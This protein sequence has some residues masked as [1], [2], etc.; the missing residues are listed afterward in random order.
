[1]LDDKNQSG[2]DRLPIFPET[3]TNQTNWD[4]PDEGVF[5]NGPYVSGLLPGLILV[6]LGI[7][8]MLSHYGYL[9]GEWWQ[10][11]IVGLGVI[12][13]IESWVQHRFITSTRVRVG[14]IVAGI[15][16]I[17]GG[18]LFLFDPNKWWPIILIVVGI[19][20]II[21]F[22]IVRRQTRFH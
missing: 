9:E 4:N 14:R 2:K 13:I 7:L 16:L 11:F 20:L 15:L 1:M 10:Y 6:V 3:K 18:L 19:I 5:P 8:F 12:F 22:I 21:R 17:V